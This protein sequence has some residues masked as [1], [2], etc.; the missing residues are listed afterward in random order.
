MHDFLKPK[1]HILMEPEMRYYDS[2]IK[3]L[4]DKPDSTYRHTK[5]VGAHAREYWDNYHTLLDDKDLVPD[6]PTRRA[7]DPRLRKLDTSCLLTGNLWRR[8]PIQHRTAYSDHTALLLMHMSFA[9][10]TNSIFQRSGLVRQLWWAP[11]SAKVAVCPSTARAKKSFDLA[12]SMG[13]TM[14]EVA[15][16]ACVET[17]KRHKVESPRA[18]SIDASV[19]GV[20]QRSM[21]KQGLTMPEGRQMQRALE[22][23]PAD[24]DIYT[25]DNIYATTCTT[26]RD[27]TAAV[28]SYTK[29]VE[30]IKGL[31]P[32][33]RSKKANA[34][35]F[36]TKHVRYQQC[37]DLI[38]HRSDYVF[39]NTEIGVARAT[40]VLDMY[41]RL[42][43]LE[44]NYA[45]VRDTKPKPE[46]LL[47]LQDEIIALEKTVNEFIEAKLG[48]MLRGALK[49]VL[50]DLVTASAQP[51]LLQ[52]DRRQYEPLQ[53]HPHEFWP[54][55][56]VCLI[57]V[58]PKTTDLSAPDIANRVEG[59]KV[60]QALIKELFN[61][62]KSALSVALDRVAPNAAQDL[63]PEVP[64][65][66]DAR[67]GGRLNP[68]SMTVRMLTP[69][70]IEGLVRAFLEWPFRP[71]LV[72]MTLAQ[73][74]GVGLGGEEGEVE[75][76]QVPEE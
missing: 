61:T 56:D 53:A 5:L 24:E 13:A 10:L 66:T 27:L 39:H 25:Q 76:E 28:R 62:P 73:G 54:Q 68:G 21:E 72:E 57:D 22:A 47:P 58:M 12:V 36:V 40:I 30:T 2:F 16:I 32:S 7:D 38:S 34:H 1:R 29:H 59:A 64:E 50:D 55:Y 4:L 33:L 17:A 48:N 23:P 19:L 26:V 3:P 67:K 41:A 51:Y 11:D 71:S 15:G 37:I 8:Y 35:G 63:I 60:S 49:T 74:D 70:M 31:M 18:A 75:D 14:T 44:A 65:L 6:R 69:E 20:V 42:L 46:A 52:R 43:N 45:A 9:A